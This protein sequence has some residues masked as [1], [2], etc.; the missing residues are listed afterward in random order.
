MYFNRLLVMYTKTNMLRHF[1]EI[2]SI[3]VT[4]Q[5]DCHLTV[6]KSTLWSQLSPPLH[7]H[8]EEK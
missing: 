3:I 5:R 7:A 6:K 1:I 8:C 2:Y 4:F